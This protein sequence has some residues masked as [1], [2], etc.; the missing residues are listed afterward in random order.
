[1]ILPLAP[2]THFS[3]MLREGGVAESA[4]APRVGSGHREKVRIA[5][6]VTTPSTGTS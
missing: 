5:E 2:V 4:P 1:M 6:G 3:V